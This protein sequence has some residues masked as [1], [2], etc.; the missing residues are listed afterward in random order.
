VKRLIVTALLGLAVAF[1]LGACN[2][3]DVVSSNIRV[4][5]RWATSTLSAS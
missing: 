1:S 4:I 5:A 2:D 3:A